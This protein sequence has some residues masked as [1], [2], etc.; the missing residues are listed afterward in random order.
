MS[1][2]INR[3]L[4]Q[5]KEADQKTPAMKSNE[6]ETFNVPSD[7]DMDE[8]MER[9]HRQSGLHRIHKHMDGLM[10]AIGIY[11]DNLKKMG[12]QPKDSDHHTL[13]NH[14]QKAYDHIHE[15]THEMF[16]NQPADFAGVNDTIRSPIDPSD[17]WGKKWGVNESK[18]YIYAHRDPDN[19]IG[20]IVKTSDGHEA[21]DKNKKSLGKFKSRDEAYQAVEANHSSGH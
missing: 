9:Y 12:F 21:F 5:L 18:E 4:K 17:R 16:G 13:I 6:R 10:D 14:V 11:H 7:A 3:Y 15:Y 20:H 2:R 1:I 19:H 8:A